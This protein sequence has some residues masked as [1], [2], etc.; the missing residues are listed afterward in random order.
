MD[1]ERPVS[2][3]EPEWWVKHGVIAGVLGGITF[4]VYE[5]VFV[6]LTR[7]AHAVLMPL[8]LIG[9]IALGQRALDPGY[10][11]LVSGGVGAVVHLMFSAL[12]GVV[13]ALLAWVVPALW[14]S[15]P[16][17]LAS[18]SAW[19][20]LV[21]AVNFHLIAPWAGLAWLPG[22]STP[23]VPF[24]AHTFGFGTVLGI[25]LDSV[26]ERPRAEAD[27]AAAPPRLRRVG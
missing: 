1:T 24:L 19:G 27:R 14:E 18:A 22:R 17:L 20:L 11:L 8:R 16:A 5:M 13:F 4:V 10:S 12:F 3:K 25:Y 21:W 23:W 2:R 9:A 7:G 15:T 26:V 6:L